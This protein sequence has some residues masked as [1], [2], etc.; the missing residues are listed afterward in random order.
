MHPRQFVVAAALAFGL[1]ATVLAGPSTA[2]AA[3]KPQGGEIPTSPGIDPPRPQILAKVDLT[4][5]IMFFDLSVE[6]GEE[7]QY[8]LFVR[9]LGNADAS[10]VQ[11]DA[12]A[13]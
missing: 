3:K 4:P 1:A 12:I 7:L 11:V 9:N 8:G 5:S 6:P 2:L 13:G 10:N